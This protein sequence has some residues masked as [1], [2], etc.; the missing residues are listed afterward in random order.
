MLFITYP[1]FNLT[2][3]THE[4]VPLQRHEI[5]ISFSRHGSCHIPRH[6]IVAAPSGRSFAKPCAKPFAKPFFVKQMAK[7]IANPCVKP[8]VTPFGEPFG[9][10]FVETFYINSNQKQKLVRLCGRPSTIY[11]ICKTFKIHKNKI[12]VNI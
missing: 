12:Y 5:V 4:S 2:T 7:P 9:K 8:F 10:P 6:E 1:W 11:K 3:N